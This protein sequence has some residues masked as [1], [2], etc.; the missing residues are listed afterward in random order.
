MR[1]DVVPATITDPVIAS[2]AV[3]RVYMP[4]AS[5]CQGAR[6]GVCWCIKYDCDCQKA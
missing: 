5:D 2:A 6:G 4:D 3:V 1:V